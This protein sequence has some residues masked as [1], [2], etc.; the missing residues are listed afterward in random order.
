MKRLGNRTHRKILV[1]DGRDRAHRRRRHRRGVDGRRPGPRPLARHPRPRLRPGRARPV[2][3][4]RGELARGDGRG[5][6]RRALPARHRGARGRRPDD[7]RAL[8]RRRRRLQRRG[9]VLPRDRRRARDAR[10]HRGLLRP[11]ARVH[12]GAA[13]TARSAACARGCS[14][15]APTSTSRRSGSPGRAAYDDLSTAA[16]RSTSTSRRCCTRR[17]CCVDGCWCGRRLGELRQPLVPAQ[18][19]GDALRLLRRELRARSSPSSSSATSRSPSAIE[20]SDRWNG[21]GP[22]PARAGGGARV[23]RREL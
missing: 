4:V 12:R 9:D 6:R 23:A 14:S 18:R 1:A 20:P 16:S 11:P 17:R 8:E 2:R 15:R 19:R 22:R 13:S 21:R 5:A 7:G 3:R 10:P